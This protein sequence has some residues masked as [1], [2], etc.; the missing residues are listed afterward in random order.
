MNE[1]QLNSPLSEPAPRRSFI[2]PVLIILGC[3][4]ILTGGSFYGV[5]ATCNFGSRNKWTEVFAVGALVGVAAIV[6]CLT[7]ILLSVVWL[8]IK[9]IR[10]I[11]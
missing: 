7:I 4:V 1:P 11:Q 9:K 3:A 5:A 10:G 8:V 6:L 2:L